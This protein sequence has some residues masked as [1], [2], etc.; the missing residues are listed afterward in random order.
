MP[1]GQRGSVGWPQGRRHSE[2]SCYLMGANRL[3]IDPVEYAEK[4]QAGLRWCSGCREWQPVE[5]FGPHSRM[6]D[7]I[8]SQCREA[9]REYARTNMRMKRAAKKR[10]AA[11]G[12]S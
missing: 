3:G 2:E 9:S 4:R 8:D 12:A 1:D 6:R 11:R 7:G 5:T 10:L